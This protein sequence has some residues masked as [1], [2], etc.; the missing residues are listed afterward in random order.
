MYVFYLFV[1]VGSRNRNLF[2]SLLKHITIFDSFIKGGESSQIS[3]SY[4]KGTDLDSITARH[5]AACRGGIL[6]EGNNY[7]RGFYPVQLRPVEQNCVN[8]G[9][10]VAEYCLLIYFLILFCEAGGTG[11]S[12]YF[13][14]N[15]FGELD[16]H[17]CNRGA[18]KS[19]EGVVYGKIVRIYLIHIVIGAA[20]V[21]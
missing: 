17:R 13:H 5:K 1:A 4:H 20:A 12:R 16:L 3:R 9:L 18:V 7:T 10:A 21:V 11:N 19:L 14:G 15:G 8:A 6:S 2:Q